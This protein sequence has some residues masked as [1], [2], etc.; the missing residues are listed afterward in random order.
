MNVTLLVLWTTSV[1]SMMEN[2]SVAPI[3]MVANVMSVSLD[4][5]TSLTARGAS[6]TVMLTVAIP[7]PEPVLTVL[8]ARMDLTV[9]LAKKVTME[10]HVF[11]SVSPVVC[12][13]ALE[14]LDRD[15]PLPLG[16]CWTSSPRTLYASVKRD[17]LVLVALNVLITTSVPLTW[18]VASV[19]PANVAVTSTSPDRVTVTLLQENAWFVSVKPQ[20]STANVANPVSLEMTRTAENVTVISLAVGVLRPC[21]TTPTDSAPVYPM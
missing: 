11:L 18:T 5:G 2:V 12:V 16:V 4:T 14:L 21:V 17:I 20:V 19:V 8:A 9:L 15:K 7:S 13:H 3:P 6:V 1:T 10:T